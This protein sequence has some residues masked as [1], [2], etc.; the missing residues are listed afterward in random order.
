MTGF[1]NINVTSVRLLKD[2]WIN[3]ATLSHR[4]SNKFMPRQSNIKEVTKGYFIR[5]LFKSCQ[6][7]KLGGEVSSKRWGRLGSSKRWGRSKEGWA[8]LK[9]GAGQKKVGQF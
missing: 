2:K 4:R 3:V 5:K 7:T 9:D 6:K 1:S 8:V